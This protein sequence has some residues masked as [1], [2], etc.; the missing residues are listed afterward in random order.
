M[1]EPLRGGYFSACKF[2]AYL[3]RRQDAFGIFLIFLVFSF[4][5]NLEKSLELQNLS[6]RNKLFFGC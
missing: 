4:E 5:I 1:G 6:L 3:Q 2:L